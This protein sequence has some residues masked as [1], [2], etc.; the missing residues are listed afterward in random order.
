MLSKVK[1]EIIS[2]LYCEFVNCL[3]EKG[4]Y[5][6]SLEHTDFGMTA[7][8]LASDY[9]TV[10]HIAKK[11][12][13]R[14]KIVDK[15]G[16]YF[17]IRPF[18]KR[19]GFIAGI[20]IVFLC[21]HFFGAI[22]WGIDIVCP[23]ANI[24]KDVE[25]MLYANDIYAGSFF[26]KVKNKKVTQQI[27]MKVDNVGYVTLNFYKGILTCR[28]DP[29][30][31]KLPYLEKSVYGD[32]TA[33]ESGIIE[34]LRVYKGFSQVQAG[35]S[36]YKGDVLV[37][38]TYTD[39]NG[40]LHRVM[41]RAYIKAFCEKEYKAQTD[42]EKSVYLRTGE[43]T[44]QIKLKLPFKDLIIEK[45]DTDGWDIFD[46]EIS[47]SAVSLAGFRIPATAEKTVFYKKENSSI[48][49]DENA[50]Y[51][52]A[53]KTVDA[54]IENDESVV[55]ITDRTYSYTTDKDALYITCRVQGYFD[56]TT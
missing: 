41:P 47:F 4:F 17:R 24:A 14:T 48:S 13:C 33:S 5:I 46:K 44:Q 49:R 40:N 15:K 56:I 38:S 1:F 54:M 30:V 45:A 2:G 31:N 34:D 39:R 35:Q 53:L 8:C 50:A 27:F 55:E 20:F 43:Y 52:A 12:Q 22:I 42:F 29:A 36:V 16:L 32:I 26:S 25:N 18:M 7:V 11:F 6:T 21:M 10:K 3:I 28:I 37:S 23:D 19:K 51:K 9:K